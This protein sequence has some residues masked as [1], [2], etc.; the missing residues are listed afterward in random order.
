VSGAYFFFGKHPPEHR[1]LV[2][3]YEGM[4]YN[5]TIAS[6]LVFLF[7]RD[8]THYDVTEHSFGRGTHRLLSR[9]V[10]SLRPITPR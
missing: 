7:T 9:L 3:G 5:V 2:G 8:G 4:L 1:A 10:A 6:H